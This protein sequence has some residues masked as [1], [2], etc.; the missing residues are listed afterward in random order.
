MQCT[1]ASERVEAPACAPDRC[2]VKSAP[3]NWFRIATKIN[4]L[5]ALCAVIALTGAWLLLDR[6]QATIERHGQTLT[7]FM[8]QMDLARRMQ[9]DF[10]KSRQLE[11]PRARAL[12][13]QFLRA[14]TALGLRYRNAL[15]VFD[16]A[17]SLSSR[18]VNH[19]VCEPLDCHLWRLR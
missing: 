17:R 3:L 6:M 11:L 13:A 8:G 12:V 4:A 19:S 1:A 5:T 15:D 16:R 18:S 14:H 2:A 10:K 7:S 9:V